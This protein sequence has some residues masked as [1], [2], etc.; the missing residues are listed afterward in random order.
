MN[1]SIVIRAINDQNPLILG[2]LKSIAGSLMHGSPLKNH[3]VDQWRGIIVI[4]PATPFPRHVHSGYITTTDDDEEPDNRPALVEDGHVFIPVRYKVTD[5]RYRTSVVTENIDD[6]GHYFEIVS[7]GFRN[8]P[9]LSYVK[10]PVSLVADVLTH[11]GVSDLSQLDTTKERIDYSDGC[12]ILSIIKTHHAQ[13]AFHR[14]IVDRCK[15]WSKRVVNNPKVSSDVKAALLL[16]AAGDVDAAL[17]YNGTTHNC[18]A[19]RSVEPTLF[20][21]HH[22]KSRSEIARLRA[23]AYSR[24]NK[25]SLNIRIILEKDE[26]GVPSLYT[27]PFSIDPHPTRVEYLRTSFGPL[28][29]FRKKMNIP[30]Y[31]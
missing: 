12:N 9:L 23:L 29:E 26:N 16:G 11:S 1:S 14:W 6:N 2:A 4:D 8:E 18:D 13:I 17:N 25:K 15:Y 7:Y 28:E 19:Y 22:R 10:I 20:K 5:V 24:F 3:N 31:Y 21:S 27:I 30:S